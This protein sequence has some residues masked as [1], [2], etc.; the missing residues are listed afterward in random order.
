[1]LK[2]LKVRIRMTGL[3]FIAG[4]LLASCSAT[5]EQ[6]GEN[7]LSASSGSVAS[8]APPTAAP[9]SNEPDFK[10]EQLASIPGKDIYLYSQQSEGVTLQV[11][12]K[13]QSFDWI[14]ATPRNIPP[15]MKALDYDGDGEDELAVDLYMGSG[16]GVSVE[17][18]RVV[19]LNDT[20]LE[21]GH[22]F[23]DH[24][25]IPDVYLGQL[26]DAVAFSLSKADDALSGLIT[27]GDHLYTVNLEPYE[28]PD[29]GSI[30]EGLVFGSIVR[31]SFEDKVIKAEFGSGI[32]AGSAVSPT[33]IG[34]IQGDVLYSDGQ[35]QLTNIQF[36][37]TDSIQ[38]EH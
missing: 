5:N 19:E 29:L 21:N 11:G 10:P 35:F 2:Q 22:F 8:E 4:L 7:S 34:V 20:G 12:E 14:Y 17:Q 15:H 6:P 25:Y 13:E 33:Y 38:I 26:H 9:V 37:E 23:K 16:T 31:F 36:A 28:T 3:L 18:L 30:N 24:V 27:I 1:M 32:T